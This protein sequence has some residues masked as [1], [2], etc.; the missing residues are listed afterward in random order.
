[1]GKVMDL[2]SHTSDRGGDDTDVM[3]DL[4]AYV[5]GIVRVKYWQNIERGKLPRSSHSSRY[6]LYSIDVGLDE[7]RHPDGLQD[8][9]SIE[10]HVLNKPWYIK[11]LTML[12]VMLP[13]WQC[14]H[15]IARSLGRFEATRDKRHYYLVV[16]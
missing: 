2:Q 11:V 8:W 10:H 16:V 14:F 7:L 1:M 12:D 15:F 5:R 6:L 9:K 3:H 4:L 13:D